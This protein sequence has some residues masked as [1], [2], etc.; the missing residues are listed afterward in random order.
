MPNL[1]C[2]HPILDARSSRVGP[3]LCA[4]AVMTKAPQFGTTK[5]RLVP[6]LTPT[7]AALLSGCFLRDTCFSIDEISKASHAEGVAVYT[8]LGAEL[9]YQGLLPASFSMLSQR[10]ET[11]GERLFFAAQDLLAVGYESLCLIDSDSPTLPQPILRDA[12]TELARPGDRVVL[13]EAIDGGYYLIG[14]KQAHQ[15]LFA[16]IDWSTSKVLKQT[17]DRAAE[18]N[19]EVTVLPPWYDVDDAETLDRLCEEM[20]ATNGHQHG[21]NNLVAYHAVHTRRYLTELIQTDNGR[22]RIW[23]TKAKRADR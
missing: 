13:G 3:N 5:T 2:S 19:L 21:Q 4:L 6:P 15:H 23:G 10:G 14:L 20:F 1:N 18:L 16:N 17:I 8:P 11:F 9:I 7:E 12:V 22:H